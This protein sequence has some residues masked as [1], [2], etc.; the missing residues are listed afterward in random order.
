MNDREIDKLL[1]G[2]EVPQGPKAETL[3]R[4]A[5]SIAESI[6]PVRVLPPRWMLIGGAAM[7]CATVPLLG[8]LALGFAGIVKMSALERATVLS[9]LVILVFA[10][11]SELVSAIVPGGRRRFSSGGL[12]VV[13]V[14]CLAVVLA[15]SFRDYPTTNFI[16][17][18]LVC[19]A[20][21]LVHAIAAGLLSW[22]VLRRGVAMDPI[23]AGLV[24][25]T[26]EGLA[27]IGMLEL[28]CPNFQAA[29][30]LVWHLGVLVMSAA[31]GL[32]C[33]WTLTRRSANS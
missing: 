10:S 15:A 33:G 27:G 12:L 30:V 2:A 11:A 14:L 5:Q 16:H 20:V 4:I 23:S 29:H 32:L 6:G 25:G 18:G 3:G 19:L 1:N 8:A 7:I 24:G 31:L 26:L 21:G 17:A 28:H 9:T 13:A 22:L